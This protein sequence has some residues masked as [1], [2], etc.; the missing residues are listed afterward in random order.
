MKMY[1][2]SRIE[3]VFSKKRAINHF[4]WEFRAAFHKATPFHGKSQKIE[5]RAAESKVLG[6]N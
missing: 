4:L 2:I 1:K 6:S 3:K 5:K